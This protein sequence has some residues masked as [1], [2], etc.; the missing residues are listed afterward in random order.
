MSLRVTK[1]LYFKLKPV[2]DR[3]PHLKEVLTFDVVP[4]VRNYTEILDLGEE[5]RPELEKVLEETKIRLH[6]MIWQPSFTP[7][8]PQVFPKG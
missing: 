8:G 4:G 3:L 2:A 7:Q 1:K 5:K 6:P